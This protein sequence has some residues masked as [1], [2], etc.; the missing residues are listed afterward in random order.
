MDLNKIGRGVLGNAF[1]RLYGLDDTNAVGTLAPEIMPVVS[2]WER[3][4][5]WALVGGSLGVARRAIVAGGAGVFQKALL[6]NPPGSGILLIVERVWNNTT[7][8]EMHFGLRSGPLGLYSLSDVFH[9]DTRRI[10]GVATNTGLGAQWG[11]HT[12]ASE[13]VIHGSVVGHG[14]GLLEYVLS[15][16][17]GIVF[18]SP[19]NGALDMT[20]F[21]RER[22]AGKDEQNIL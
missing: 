6:L 14:E 22:A 5:F 18:Q 2:I 19:S 3:P 16:G 7:E 1:A 20:V 9:R 21:F 4:E 17:W 13:G 15:P 10:W 11:L 8:T 12:G